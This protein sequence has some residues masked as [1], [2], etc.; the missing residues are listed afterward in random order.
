MCGWNQCWS[1]WE[2]WTQPETGVKE[3]CCGQTPLQ[4]TKGPSDDP[5]WRQ[6][7]IVFAGGQGVSHRALSD[8]ERGFEYPWLST[9]S[10]NSDFC[11]WLHSLYAHILSLVWNWLKR[12]IALKIRSLCIFCTGFY[13]FKIKT[14]FIYFSF[15]FF[16]KFIDQLNFL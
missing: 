8:T 1:K 12:W 9:N 13:F 4:N 11:P 3:R 7:Q 2:R 15:S 10:L 16:R 5:S 6:V 14:K